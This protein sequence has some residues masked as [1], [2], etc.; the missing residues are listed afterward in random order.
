MNSTCKIIFIDESG[1]GTIKLNKN[2]LWVTAGILSMLDTHG[3]LTEDFQKMKEILMRN[4]SEEFKGSIVPK[5]LLEGKTENDV[6]TEISNLMRKYEMTAW[7]TATD[8]NYAQGSVGTFVPSNPKKGLQAKDIARELL[9]ERVSGY[10]NIQN[11][12]SCVYQLIWDLSDVYELIDFS[13]VASNYVDPHNKRSLNPQI[14]PKILGAL[15][16][17]WVELQI[18]D[19]L[20]NF[21]LNYIAMG[22]FDDAD[23]EKSQAFKEHLY[24][25]L[26]RSSKRRDGVGWKTLG[27]NYLYPP[28]WRNLNE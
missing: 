1:A 19:V 4:P 14:I 21:A 17:D 16:H 26:A 9:L 27:L 20:S 23:R 8:R 3:T 18:A 6:A 7:I 22:K 28:Q 11:N 10:V 24:P 5:H 12:D 25:M 15:S 2:S 13:H